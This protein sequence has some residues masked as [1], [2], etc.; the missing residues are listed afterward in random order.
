MMYGLIKHIANAWKKAE[1]KRF[2]GYYFGFAF[3]AYFL[4]LCS[5]QMVDFSRDIGY[6]LTFAL[7]FALIVYLG[8]FARRQL[9]LF[10]IF[11][12]LYILSSLI[13]LKTE[14]NVPDRELTHTLGVAVI[15]FSA[16]CLL[17]YVAQFVNMRFLRYILQLLSGAMYT[18]FLIFPLSL[19]GYTLVND[20]VFSADIM[21][22]LFQTNPGEIGAYLHDRGCSPYSDKVS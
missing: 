4:R 10:V 16:V 11:I 8:D 18:L 7:L 17:H 14:I 22:T 5:N 9:L 19:I 13:K 2:I 20:A 6:V 12:G 15:A 1:F 3:F 21:L